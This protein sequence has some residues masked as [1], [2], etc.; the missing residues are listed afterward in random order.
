M[1]Q[2]SSLTQSA[3]SVRQVL[4][5]YIHLACQIDAVHDAAKPDVR[6]DHGDLTPADQQGCKRS[7]RAFALDGVQLFIF[8]QRRRQAVILIRL[9]APNW[10]ESYGSRRSDD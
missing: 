7:L 8:E 6:E 2:Q 1:S 3:H 10:R 5:A 9:C 4:T